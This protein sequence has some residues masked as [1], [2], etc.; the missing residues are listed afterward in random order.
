[1]VYDIPCKL[2]SHLR[3]C[4]VAVIIGGLHCPVE[5][6]CECTYQPFLHVIPSGVT[7]IGLFSFIN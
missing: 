1:M 5:V 7:F 3:F 6:S 2:C 4:Q